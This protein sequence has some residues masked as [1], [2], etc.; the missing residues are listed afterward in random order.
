VIDTRPVD[1]SLPAQPVYWLAIDPTGKGE[2]TSPATEYIKMDKLDADGKV[3]FNHVVWD[4]D[5]SGKDVWGIIAAQELLLATSITQPACASPGTGSL[6]V[7]ILGGRA[8]YQLTVKNGAGLPISRTIDNAASPID[9]NNLNTGKYFLKII[10]AAQHIYAD[11]FYINNQDA[12]VPVALAANYGMI[13]GRTLHLNAA[14]DMPDGLSWEWNGPGNFHSF[15]PQ[16]TIIEPGLYTLRCS[17]DGC[18]NEQDVMVT[19]APDNILC[20]V[21]VYPNP[22]SSAFKARVTLDKPGQ[23]TMSVYTNDGKLISMQKGDNRAHYLFTG[24]LK[25]SGVYELVFTSGLSKTSKRL[26]IVK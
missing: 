1:A 11:S 25:T 15:N 22:S 26:V 20:D 6:Q 8:P 10:D 23:V 7:K 14:E 4:K 16:V 5:G 3:F 19:V 13:H 24:E 21:T 9:I 2:F 17:K 12:P 18:S